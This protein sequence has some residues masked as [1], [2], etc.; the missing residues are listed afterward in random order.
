MAIHFTEEMAARKARL[1]AALADARLDGALLFA[2]ESMYWLTGYDTFGFCFFQCLFVGAD[3]RM[4]LLTRSA[5]LR[6]AQHTS[7]ISDIRIWR[8]GAGAEPARDLARLLVD[9]GLRAALGV[10]FDTLRP[11][12][13]PTACK[14]DA[15]LAAVELVDAPRSP[16]LRVTKSAAEIAYVREAARLSDAA[17]RAALDATSAGAD[18]GEILAAQHHAIFAGGGDYPGNEF[19]IGSGADALLCR[20]KSGRRR[21]DADDQI[22]LEFAGVYRHYHAAIMRTAVVGEPRPLHRAY[23]AAAREALDAC[24]AELRPAARRATSS[25]PMPAC[26]TPM[27]WRTSPQRLRLFA[28]REVHAVVDGPADVL[29]RQPLPSRRRRG[30]FPAH[31]PDGQRHETALCLGPTYVTTAGAAEPFNARRSGPATQIALPL[32]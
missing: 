8:D 5:D 24:E 20:Y 1:F 22:T 2:Q 3:G 14:L 12:L 13:L 19:I 32:R 18:E 29:R 4:A 7:D 25:P 9:L 31:D 30:L 27:G 23:H 21:L 15:A 11:D 26:S 16:G 17:D 6:Q 10:E 28:R